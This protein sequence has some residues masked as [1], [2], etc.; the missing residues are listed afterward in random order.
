MK[1]ETLFFLLTTV[2]EDNKLASI[3]IFTAD[4]PAIRCSAVFL[5]TGPCFFS[6]LLFLLLP[7]G[8]LGKKMLLKVDNACFPFL[9]SQEWQCLKKRD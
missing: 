2:K 1:T 5:R 9:I 4:F 3:C 7:H 8:L 6:P